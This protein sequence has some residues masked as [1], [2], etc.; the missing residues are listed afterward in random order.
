MVKETQEAGAS[1]F[2]SLYFTK[3]EEFEGFIESCFNII[4]IQINI[5]LLF[6]FIS[7]MFLKRNKYFISGNTKRWLSYRRDP[8][9]L[10]LSATFV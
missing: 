3:A 7:V 5:S 1:H 2:N 9:I 10:W 6:I 8:Q 4:F